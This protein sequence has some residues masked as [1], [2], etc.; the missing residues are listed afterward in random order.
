MRQVEA[1]QSHSGDIWKLRSA[2]PEMNIIVLGPF[3]DVLEKG[4]VRAGLN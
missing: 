1:L 4:Y 3:S 2:N